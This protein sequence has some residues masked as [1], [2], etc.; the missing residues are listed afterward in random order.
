MLRDAQDR[1]IPAL[2]DATGD[3]IIAA[4][5]AA[6]KTEAAF[7]P[8]LTHLLRSPNDLGNVLYISPIKALINDQFK[9]LG[10]LCA[11]LD[12]PVIPWHGDITQAPKRAFAKRP[13]GIVLITPESLES[14]FVNRGPRV[15]AL[16]ART[17]YIVVDELH[18]FLESERGR[19]LQSLMH[20][21]ELAAGHRVA[22]VG[23]SATLGDMQMAQHYLRPDAP[24][25][26]Q[27]IVSDSQG[28]ALKILLKGYEMAPSSNMREDIAAHQQCEHAIATHLYQTIRGSNNLVFPNS[29]SNVETFTDLLRGFSARDK[30]V[31]EFFPHHGS[32][33]KELREDAERVLKRGNQP[34]TAI[35]T[36]T[37][38]LGVDIGSVKNVVQ[39]GPPPSVASLRQRLG[40]SGRREGEPA[41]LRAYEIERSLDQRASLSDRL[42][43]GLLQSVAM[44]NLLLSGWCEPPAPGSLHASTLVQQILSVVT[45]RSGASATLLWQ[46][47]VQTGPFTGITGDAF[48][49]LLRRM[50]QCELIEQDVSGQLLLGARGERLVGHYDFYSAFQSEDEYDII[51]DGKSLGSTP[52]AVPLQEGQGLIFAGRRWRVLAVNES[53]LK[54]FVTPD[55]HGAAAL[56]PGARAAVHDRVRQEMR[57]VLE[58]DAPI[59]YLDQAA[60]TML[61]EARRFA[62]AAGLTR[63]ALIEVGDRCL[64]MTWRGDR[65]NNTVQLM[66]A[67]EDIDATNHGTYIAIEAPIGEVREMLPMVC[68]ERPP[69]AGAVLDGAVN[70][71]TE[72]WDAFVPAGTLIASYAQTKLDLDGAWEFLMSLSE[73]D[74]AI[75]Q[76]KTDCLSS[77]TQSVS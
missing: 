49:A 62:G 48:R 76:A 45:E 35:C 43:T 51:H 7:F 13:A 33:S 28:Q 11:Q 69:D 58:D 56:F 42:R 34:A 19:Q 53:G 72:K 46:V 40:R 9:R 41:I 29:R 5:T 20:R 57:Q 50:G 66:F 59:R 31:N 12:V 64:L 27:M 75:G 60:A 8:I 30:V 39:I 68:G 71:A 3:A 52:I 23:L 17:C 6:G 63:P 15:T 1:A 18:T 16:F 26:V 65:I 38:E 24:D 25:Q 54:V 74:G 21:V 67:R 70:V 36:S 55:Q 44:I 2:V 22:R 47:L 32:L 61:E 77:S 14:I 4:R 73:K 37:M 10:L